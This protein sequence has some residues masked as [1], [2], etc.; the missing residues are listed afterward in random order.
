MK[1]LVADDSRTTQ[2]LLQVILSTAGYDV[3]VA[4]DGEEVLGIIRQAPFDVV[5]MDVNMPGLDGLST[6][7]QIKGMAAE[8]PIPLLIGMSA[9][10]DAERHREFMDGGF[11][12]FFQKPLDTNA[13]KAYLA[14]LT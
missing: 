14:T 11:D 9:E 13:I 6:A 4:V 7:R 1:I 12:V 3:D 2:K 10:T 8:M 5:L